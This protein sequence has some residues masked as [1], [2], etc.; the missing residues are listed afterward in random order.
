MAGRPY[1]GGI[2]V[3]VGAHGQLVVVNEV[4]ADKL[5]EGL[6]PAEIFPSAPAAALRAQAVAAR[7]ELFRKTGVRHLVDP[8]LLCARTHCQVYAGAGHEHPR[9][10]AA[11]AATRGLVLL[12]EDG[13]VVDTVYSAVCGG[14]TEDNDAVWPAQ[15]AL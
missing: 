1:W 4:P 7:G 6:V 10:S 12:E 2:Y 11:V 9:T 14:H 3:T 5:L 15:T 8:Y 13:R